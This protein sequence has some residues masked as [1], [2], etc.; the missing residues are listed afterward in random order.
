MSVS[1]GPRLSPQALLSPNRSPLTW[2]TGPVP[3]E[4][5]R[6]RTPKI[7]HSASLHFKHNL[8]DRSVISRAI[9]APVEADAGKTKLASNEVRAVLFDMDGVLCNSEEMTQRWL[10]DDNHVSCHE[11]RNKTALPPPLVPVC[12]N[13]QFHFIVL[14]SFRVGAETLLQ[15]YGVKVDPEEF[16]S[17]AGMGEAYFLSG[18]AGKYGLQIDDINKLKK[19]F[20]GIYLKKAADPTENIGLPGELQIFP[21]LLTAD[22]DACTESGFTIIPGSDAIPLCRRH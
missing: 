1:S 15:V 21:A 5:L 9:S 12:F 10:L 3:H 7:S 17:F 11:P 19:I 4:S 18:V 6:K 20:Y 22:R 2:G 16:R 14:F 13:I 8:A